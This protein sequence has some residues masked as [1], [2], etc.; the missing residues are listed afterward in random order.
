MRK[1]K[2]FT[3]LAGL[4]LSVGT[5][6]A[7]DPVVAT[8]SCGDNL[9]WT[10]TGVYP[11]YTLT[12]SA[13]GEGGGV[14][15]D[16]FTY[17]EPLVPWRSYSSQFK[18]IVI[19]EGV[20]HLGS[21]A[22][23][24]TTSAIK[25]IV[26]P[27]GVVSI[28][29]GCFSS[30]WFE[31]I[32]L[33]NSLRTIGDEAFYSNSYKLKSITIPEGVTS[34]G[35]ECF[36]DCWVLETISLPS[37][38]QSIGPW[39][40]QKCKVLQSLEIP[41][42]VSSIGQGITY[43]CTALASLSVAAGNTTFDSRDNCNAIIEK[44]T[45]KLYAGCKNSFI[46]STVESIKSYAFYK[47]ELEEINI[48]NGVTTIESYAFS[49]TN[50]A[51]LSISAS[52][53][54][55]H[56]AAF[57][58]QLSSIVVDENNTTYDSR[59]NCNAIIVTNSNPLTLLKG[60]LNAVIP[61]AVQTIGK[62]AF[63]DF[64]NLV[65]ISIPSNVSLI[66]YAA[67][68]GCTGLTSI[69][70][71]AE[72]P[73]LLRESTHSFENVNSEIPVYVPQSSLT[74]YQTNT[75]YWNYF[76]NFV[77]MD[78][79][80]LE[81]EAGDDAT[82]QLNRCTG[83]LTIAGEGDMKSEELL[84]FLSDKASVTKVII[85]KNITSIGM[86]C[87]ANLPNLAEVEFE[88]PSKVDRIEDL[89][90]E[91][92]PSLTS[93][94]LP[95]SLTDLGNAFEMCENLAEVNFSS[96]EPPTITEAFD[97][98]NKRITYPGDAKDS[99]YVNT[100]PLIHFWDGLYNAA[101][102]E[103]APKPHA[104]GKCGDNVNWDF[105]MSVKSGGN[106][107]KLSDLIGTLTISGTGESY[108]YHVF[109]TPW[110]E[111]YEW[112]IHNIRIEE[113]V[114]KI[115][116]NLFAYVGHASTIVIPASVQ[117][118]GANAFYMCNQPKAEVYIS[119]NPAN[120][121]WIDENHDDFYWE[122]GDEWDD[123]NFKATICYVPSE[124]FAGYMSKWATGN[125]DTDV[126][127]KF[128]VRGL[129]DI[130]T[131]TGINNYLNTLDGKTVPVVT[132]TRPVPRNGYFST[133][134]VPFDMN[135]AQIASS[136]LSGAEIMEFT[137]ATNDAEGLYLTFS[138]VDHIEAGKPYFIRYAEADQLE[139]LDFTNVTIDKSEPVGVKRGTVTMY[140]T[141]LPKHVYAQ[142][143]ETDGE[144]L[145]FLASENRLFWPNTEGNIKPF[146]C[147]FKVT[148]GGGAGA[149]RRGM[150]AYILEAKSPESATGL[151][152]VQGDNEKSFKT[153]ENGQLVIIR[154]GVK[155]NAAG[156]IVK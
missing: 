124:Y 155:Y 2:L 130:E 75:K 139:K 33:P 5:M 97:F 27:E 25:S 59:G 146:R 42:N 151:N 117:N 19:N 49:L 29:K 76:S 14:M 6:F 79:C 64:P 51:P 127:V 129:S 40:F 60:S 7:D 18:S 128:S 38:L 90:F 16:F 69:R 92:C 58:C 20:T 140:G 4:M 150:P 56:E 77:G 98:S 104:T 112:Y 143:S 62:Y 101:T 47:I 54:N 61:E 74:A 115:G 123:M 28:G 8:G 72:N 106:P 100:E 39:A 122:G 43:E 17:K 68:A 118:I 24:S 108:D 37:T 103:H 23:S 45:N 70:C 149:P 93:I 86:E 78:L 44:A 136:S 114:T 137:N 145:L 148:T 152:H 41:E 125:E 119:A 99:L 109:D 89:A 22:F 83:E 31:T 84:Q 85:G 57:S 147:Y 34:I 107:Y 3:L 96:Q 65:T 113:G 133:L 46:P 52:V 95:A 138:P 87:F 134:C 82:W 63:Y 53:N 13:S 35:Q 91:N 55:I 81:G 116:S 120:L 110:Y 141:Y 88:A 132:I 94:T 156:Q 144:G 105:S 131:E 32:T 111:V 50:S 26:V 1:L 67:F 21:S 121:T 30:C 73:P 10:V 66:E 48:P 153:I 12:I 126:N 102:N 15:T 80:E 71:Y 142:T 9:I 36:R 11:N 154:N 135:A